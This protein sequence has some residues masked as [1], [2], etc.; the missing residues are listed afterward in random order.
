MRTFS[1][2]LVEATKRPGEDS[3]EARELYFFIRNSKECNK[4]FDATYK[5]LVNKVARG[6]YD[7]SRAP[8]A[9]VGV[10]ERAMELY[11]EKHTDK[12]TKIKDVFLPADRRQVASKLAKD[13]EDAAREGDYSYFLFK[14]YVD[15]NG[16]PTEEAD[17]NI[18]AL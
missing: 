14:K 16:Y 4:L 7:A 8:V 6:V 17:K 9:F 2:F 12:K 13:F 10:V 5:N 15:L 11:K 18:K 3:D 1:E